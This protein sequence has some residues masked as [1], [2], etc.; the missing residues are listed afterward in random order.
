MGNHPPRSAFP[1]ATGEGDVSTNTPPLPLGTT[2]HDDGAPEAR[3][4]PATSAYPLPN[5]THYTGTT[6]KPN[7]T[8][9]FLSVRTMSVGSAP[10]AH[11]ATPPSDR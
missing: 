6:G 8:P 4:P 5:H 3:N 10:G 11:C 2:R 9:L 7:T 1:Y